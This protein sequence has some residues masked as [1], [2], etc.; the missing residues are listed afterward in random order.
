MPSHVSEGF[1]HHKVTPAF[2]PL[3]LAYAPGPL[4]QTLFCVCAVKFN[5]DDICW[6]L[7]WVIVLPSVRV[8]RQKVSVRRGK[9]FGEM[10]Y[11]RHKI[12]FHYQCIV[13]LHM[14][15]LTLIAPLLLSFFLSSY[16]KCLL[17]M[18]RFPLWQC[19]GLCQI[20]RQSNNGLIWI[21]LQWAGCGNEFPPLQQIEL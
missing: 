1:W 2:L 21:Y 12:H 18:S 8:C 15:P 17:V 7:M 9:V 5:Q 4:T 13:L 3:F 14:L 16:V 6:C 10:S 20:M 11:V 19:A